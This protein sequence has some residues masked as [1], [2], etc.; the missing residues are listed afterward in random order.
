MGNSSNQR[1]KQYLQEYDINSKNEEEGILY[2]TSKESK[3]EYFLK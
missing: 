1:L 2:L 3:K